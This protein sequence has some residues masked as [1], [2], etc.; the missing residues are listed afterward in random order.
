MNEPRFREH[1]LRVGLWFQDCWG[2]G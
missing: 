2:R 1:L